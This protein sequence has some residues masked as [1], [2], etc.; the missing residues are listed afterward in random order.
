M[1]RRTAHSRT[2]KELEGATHKL[3]E[4]IGLEERH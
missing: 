2:D 3:R 1:Q 4:A